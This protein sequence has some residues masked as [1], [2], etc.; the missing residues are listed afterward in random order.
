MLSTKISDLKTRKL[1]YRVEKLK[2]VKKFLF[3]NCLNNPKM[4][5]AHKSSLLISFLKEKQKLKEKTKIRITNICI[6]NNRNKG[7]LRPYGI[8]RILLRNMFQFGVIP[9][10]AKA[11]W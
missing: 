10:Y 6:F 1:F 8:S 7:V 3:I 4:R 11:V 2:K 5:C 9:G